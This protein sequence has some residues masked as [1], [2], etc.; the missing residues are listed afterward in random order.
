[1]HLLSSDRLLQDCCGLCQVT[2]TTPPSCCGAC[3][4]S[5]S[6]QNHQH[7]DPGAY[8]APINELLPIQLMRPWHRHEC[9]QVPAH[10]LPFPKSNMHCSNDDTNKAC[11]Q[12]RDSHTPDKINTV[13]RPFAGV[14]TSQSMSHPA[15]CCATLCPQAPH[16]STSTPA[17]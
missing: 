3:H 1:L 11:T 7:K 9:S 17:S 2:C 5:T 13:Q 16:C 4:Q 8:S 6:Q 12:R 15:Y 10:S 14:G